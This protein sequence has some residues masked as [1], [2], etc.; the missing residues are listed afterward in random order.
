[1][2]KILCI[3]FILCWYNSLYAQ[4][5]IALLFGEKLNTGNLQFGIEV[6]PSLTNISNIQSRVKD[7][8]NLGIY[9]NIKMKERLLIHIEGVAKGTFG[10]KSI[11]P[12]STGNDTLDNLFSEGSVTRK[13]KAFSLPVMLRYGITDLFFVDAGIQPN[14]QLGAKD[15]FK[16]TVNDN[17]LTYTKNINDQITLLDFGLTA[18][19]EYKF[20]KAK[21]S[22]GIGIRYFGG[23][24]DIDKLI[25]GKQ[26]N[27]AWLFNV[28]IPIG[29]GKAA[30][31]EKETKK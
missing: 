27:N 3:V 5:I 19:V 2:K 24:V 16:S 31:K 21:S 20:S 4:V 8:L 10:A 23:L 9:L 7:G 13:I 28:T 14:M 11:I 1:M 6:T 30:A 18:G 15:I 26:A 22:M 17:E 29:T 25:P 12:Y